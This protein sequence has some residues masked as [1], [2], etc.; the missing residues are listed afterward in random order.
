M[1]YIEFKKHKPRH[2]DLVLCWNGTITLPAIY[3]DNESF[4]G[5]YYYTTF[6]HEYSPTI[7]STVKLKD[8]HKIEGVLK[9]KL[10]DEPEN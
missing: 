9:W 5:F 4:C 10:I 8:K 7:Y 1:E 3:F 2:K 6:Y